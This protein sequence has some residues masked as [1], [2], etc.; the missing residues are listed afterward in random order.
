[1]SSAR[2]ADTSAAMDTDAP[3]LQQ[4]QRP[5]QQALEQP[6]SQSLRQPSYPNS[7]PFGN[8]SLQVRSRPV[9]WVVLFT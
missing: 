3:Q 4:K 2:S 1:M 6:P 7:T 5:Q 8:D 9:A